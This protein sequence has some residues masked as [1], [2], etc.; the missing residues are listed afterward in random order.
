MD[1]KKSQ[2]EQSRDVSVVDDEK[3]SLEQGTIDT[4]DRRVSVV[5]KDGQIVNA[6]GHRDQL[7]RQYGLLSICGLA[8]T[9]DNAWVAL[10]G[11]LT[12]SI[13]NGGP[14]GV[15]YELLT[16]CVFYGFVAASIAEL[17]SA[18]PSAGGVYHWASIT[19]GVR[20]GRTVGFFT[21][22]LNFF[23][24]IFD[25]ASIVSIPA[26]IC[27]EFYA[28]FHPEFVVE[29]WHTYLAF[30]C[31]TWLG[32]AICIFGNR[33][34]PMM[35]N[36]GLFLIIVGGLVTIIVVAAM[37]ETHATTDFVW[38]AWDNQTGWNGGVAFLTGVLNGAFVIGTPDGV[39][40]M[41]E[42]L[43]NPKRDLPKAI[44]AQIILGTLTAFLYAV[45]IL[46]A[47]TDL[48]AVLNSN[49]S[50]PL[51]E[52][53]AQATR[54]KGGTFGLLIIIF[55]S[56]MICVVGT[57]LTVGRIW[58]SLARDNAT[59][60]PAFF[61]TVN[62]TL[63][64]PVPATILCAFLC[65]GFGAIMLGS[66]TA[67][68]DLVGSFII[69]T[70]ASYLLAI[71]PHLLTGRKNVPQGPFW[72]GKAGFAI[73]AIACILIIFFD[74][75]FCFRKSSCSSWCMSVTDNISAYAMPVDSSSMN[76][77]SVILVGV[78]FITVVWWFVHGIR[79]YPGPKLASVYLDE[80][81]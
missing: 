42:E 70:T 76:Y 75:M 27:V 25:L 18:V 65:T 36:A 34:I 14:P 16:A 17:A 7:Q 22:A 11:S 46:Y 6:S 5:T 61:G 43:P 26:N 80:M 50:F 12:V 49:G 66:S 41:A 59:P 3:A 20:W 44:A 55:L 60:F 37:P 13:L 19:P 39:T 52:V 28:V 10:G 62:E 53:Y 33:L 81:E 40:H 56:V 79:K 31:I 35:Q 57:F 23:G 78:L 24:W 54:S 77:N 30:V 63:S 68:T 29:P 21:G 74:V 9:I 67:F 15:L 38:R 1:A 48:D 51:A 45:S 4:T 32:C 71:G 72:M 64:C 69:L 8:L 58:W 73:N 47:I 2:K